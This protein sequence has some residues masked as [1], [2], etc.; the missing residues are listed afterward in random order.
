M[1]AYKRFLLAG[2]SFIP[3]AIKFPFFRKFVKPGFVKVEPITGADDFGKMEAALAGGSYGI[4]SY[5]CALLIILSNLCTKGG[6]TP[7]LPRFF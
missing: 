7:G 5:F 4:F 1:D 2:D 6:S 3:K